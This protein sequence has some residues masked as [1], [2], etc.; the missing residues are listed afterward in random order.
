[1]FVTLVSMNNYDFFWNVQCHVGL[2]NIIVNISFIIS[3]FARTE[4]S[5][6]VSQEYTT[7]IDKTEGKQLFF[8]SL[9][10][11]SAVSL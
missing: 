2:Y 8:Y 6:G 1:M 10:P 7:I 5:A 4:Q 9:S 3:V 11:S